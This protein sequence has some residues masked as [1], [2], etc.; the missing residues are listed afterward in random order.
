LVDIIE[1]PETI[2]KYYIRS[3]KNSMEKVQIWNSSTSTPVRHALLQ[4][5]QGLINEINKVEDVNRCERFS[6]LMT[7]KIDEKF[8]DYFI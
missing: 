2:E 5:F 8:I 1:N 7:L 3:T 4:Y 6:S